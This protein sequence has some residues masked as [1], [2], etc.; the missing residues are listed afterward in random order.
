MTA[1]LF[2][3]EM[4]KLNPKST[5]ARG[6]PRQF[7]TSI[8]TGEFYSL[9]SRHKSN[10]YVRE[11]KE[12]FLKN[13]EQSSETVVSVTCTYTAYSSG[14]KPIVFSEEGTFFPPKDEELYF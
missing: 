13:L 11:T 3:A 2:K 14:F 8:N 5:C 12:C 10:I 6:N 4:Q 1:L 9:E 7:S